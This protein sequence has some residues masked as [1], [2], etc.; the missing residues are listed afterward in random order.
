MVA[1]LLDAFLEHR[2]MELTH[3]YLVRK[4]LNERDYEELSNYWGE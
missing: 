3:Y 2:I 4:L 1:W